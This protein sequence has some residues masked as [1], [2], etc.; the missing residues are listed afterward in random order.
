[1]VD[2]LESEEETPVHAEVETEHRA[3]LGHPAPQLL[4]KF[5]P[6]PSQ[7]LRFLKRFPRQRLLKV[8]LGLMTYFGDL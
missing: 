8:H 5:K 2:K 3:C 7:T 4:N 1:M 6:L